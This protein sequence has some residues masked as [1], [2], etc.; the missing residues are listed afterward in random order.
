MFDKL[1]PK[2]IL[3]GSRK[4]YNTVENLKKLVD[5]LP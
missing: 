2:N 4:L 3:I 5:P 1:T